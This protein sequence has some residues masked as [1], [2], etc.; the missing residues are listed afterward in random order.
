VVRDVL[1]WGGIIPQEEF[2]PRHS[3]GED[4]YNPMDQFSKL[5]T[6]ALVMFGE[7]DT[8]A[9]PLQGS[10]AYQTAFEQ[11]GNKFFQVVILEHTDHNMDLTDTGCWKEQVENYRRGSGKGA[12]P[13]F[14]RILSEWLGLLKAHF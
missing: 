9:D 10:A 13:E 14:L 7:K 2:K 6:P 5:A 4:F 3:D 1:G 12:N 8:Q 11:N